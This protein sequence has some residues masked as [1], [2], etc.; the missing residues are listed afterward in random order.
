MATGAI[1]KDT[2]SF[3]CWGISTLVHRGFD[4]AARGWEE[5]RTQEFIVGSRRRRQSQSSVV[6]D[7]EEIAGSVVADR[8][9]SVKRDRDDALRA[10]RTDLER[11]G[12][13]SFF[14][15]FP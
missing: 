1:R 12:Y 14:L 10:D 3:G 8:L 6:S 9:A 5:H 13:L 11:Y 15:T 2:E 7:A 4:E